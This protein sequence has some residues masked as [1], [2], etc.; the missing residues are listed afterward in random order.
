MLSIACAAMVALFDFTEIAAVLPLLNILFKSE[1]PHAGSPRKVDDI[2]CADHRAQRPGRGSSADFFRLRKA[3]DL[4]APELSREY[5]RL[6]NE[7][8]AIKELVEGTPSAPLT[9]PI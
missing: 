8:D 7:S 5:Q 1:N 3:G 4:Q 9:C 6:D 2:G